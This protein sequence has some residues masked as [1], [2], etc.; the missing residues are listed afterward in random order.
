MTEPSTSET[1]NPKAKSRSWLTGG[2][3]I[4]WTLV[5][6]LTLRSP[7]PFHVKWILTMGL[8]ASGILGVSAAVSGRFLAVLESTRNTMS[9]SQFQLV[10]WTILLLSAFVTIGAARVFA[11]VSDPLGIAMDERLWALLGIS[12][13]AVVGTPLIYRTKE[14]KPATT[15]LPARLADARLRS[16]DPEA[17]AEGL[18]FV[19]KEGRARVEDLFT[20]DEVGDAGRVDLGK[21][22]LFFFTAIAALTYA[23]ALYARFKTN[24]AA[25]LGFPELSNGLIAILGISHATHLA[26]KIPDRAA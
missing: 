17:S 11:N 9:L 1:P 7:W 24:D 10:L 14:G 13:A 25:S 22:Q 4:A 6:Y 20:G 5:T 23:V 8:L 2:V 26:A 3:L 12:T 19:K 16:G 18:L 15:P 21:V